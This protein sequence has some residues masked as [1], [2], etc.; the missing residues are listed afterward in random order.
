MSTSRSLCTSGGS[1]EWRDGAEADELPNVGENITLTIQVSNSGTTT[2]SEFCITGD[3]LFDGCQ[4]C[5]APETLAP[6]ELFT[7]SLDFKVGISS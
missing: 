6:E 4:E 2:L 5:Q 3:R 7:C 1:A